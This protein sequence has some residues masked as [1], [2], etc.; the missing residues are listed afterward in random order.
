MIRKKMTHK[1]RADLKLEISSIPLRSINLYE[2]RLNI[3]DYFF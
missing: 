1:N 3:D 2:A